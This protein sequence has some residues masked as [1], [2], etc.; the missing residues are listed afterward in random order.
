MFRFIGR[1]WQQCYFLNPNVEIKFIYLPIYL[2][3]GHDWINHRLDSSYILGNPNLVDS[4]ICLSNFVCLLIFFQLTFLL[5]SFKT[6]LFGIQSHANSYS[7]FTVTQERNLQGFK[8]VFLRFFLD[9][10]AKRVRRGFCPPTPPLNQ[11]F[12]LSES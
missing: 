7:S 4:V 6:E 1:Y 3:T 11:F 8:Q 2:F 10:Q 5:L 12:A 9:N